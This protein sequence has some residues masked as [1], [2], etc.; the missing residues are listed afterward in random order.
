[1]IASTRRRT[2]RCCGS[3]VHKKVNI[4]MISAILS[5][6]QMK[7]LKIKRLIYSQSR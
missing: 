7:E 6:C 3:D 5:L 4:L 1:M 2:S